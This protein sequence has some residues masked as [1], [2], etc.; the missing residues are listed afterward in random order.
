MVYTTKIQIFSGQVAN[1]A[2]DQN[3]TVQLATDK[4]TTCK[5]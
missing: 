1:G 2:Q 4:N 3:S 5:W